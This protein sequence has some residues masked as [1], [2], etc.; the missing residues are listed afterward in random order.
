MSAA[1]TDPHDLAVEYIDCSISCQVA[2]G[3]GPPTAER[4]LAAIEKAE[5]EFWK[6]R[7]LTSPGVEVAPAAPSEGTLPRS[8]DWS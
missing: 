7:E 8:A 5:R 3:Y 4:R 6:L 2:L 1:S